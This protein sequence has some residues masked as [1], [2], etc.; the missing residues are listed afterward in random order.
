MLL[1]NRIRADANVRKRFETL[2]DFVGNTNDLAFTVVLPPMIATG[3]VVVI[4]ASLRVVEKTQ[5]PHRH[6]RIP[7][8]ER[9][10]CRWAQRSSMP[11]KI[12]FFPRQKQIDEPQNTTS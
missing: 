9:R 1:A 7:T 5:L 12:P 11:E 2:G 8:L 4:N 3:N 10:R 6:R